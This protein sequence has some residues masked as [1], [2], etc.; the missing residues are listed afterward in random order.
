MKFSDSK[1][2]IFYSYL[3]FPLF[4]IFCSNDNVEK[5]ANQGS[6]A[7]PVEAESV[8]LG[9]S[10]FVISLSYKTTIA[11]L[12]ESI[13]KSEL[14][15]KVSKVF[16][17]TGDIVK[18]GDVILQFPEGSTAIQYQQA[19]TA[20]ENIEKSYLRAKEQFRNNLISQKELKDIGKQYDVSKQNFESIKRMI[21]PESPIDGALLELF[22]KEGEKATIGKELFK[23]GDDKSVV[24]PI[25]VT[26]QDK[27]LLK[28]GMKLILSVNGKDYAGRLINISDTIDNKS[29]NYMATAQFGNPGNTL[30]SGAVAEIRIDVYENKS[31]LVIPL[32]CI[33]IESGNK[34][35]YIDSNG[36]AR[37]IFIKTGKESGM[38]TEV[39]DGLN[40]GDRLIVSGQTLLKDGDSVKA[41]K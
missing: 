34:Y 35:V 36:I 4:F 17:K 12:N 37:K 18:K 20:F 31:A 10:P 29:G 6:N 26:Q 8:I 15:D 9:K 5:N 28:R 32:K 30:K 39:I 40:P 24:A 7:G 33:L 13:I 21:Y 14:N 22:V 11:G 38:E 2:L 1:K 23:V 19:K 16:F 3:F 27:S 41:G 25:L